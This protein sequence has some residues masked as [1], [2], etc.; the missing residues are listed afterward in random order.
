[1][2]KN[3]F[4]HLLPLSAVPWLEDCRAWI[5]IKMCCTG[6]PMRSSTRSCCWP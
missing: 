4:I 5:W 1:M 6:T 3:I 2:Y